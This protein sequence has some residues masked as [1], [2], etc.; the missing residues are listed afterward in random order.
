MSLCLSG[1][2]RDPTEGQDLKKKEFDSIVALMTS[3]AGTSFHTHQT[4]RVYS[5]SIALSRVAFPNHKHRSISSIEDGS[6]PDTEDG[7][8]VQDGGH[9]AVPNT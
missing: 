5:Y 6:S 2:D 9:D 4:H 8:A 1:S 3:E 7:R